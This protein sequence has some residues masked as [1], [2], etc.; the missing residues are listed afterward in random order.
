MI[1]VM[2]QGTPLEVVHGVAESLT[3]WNIEPHVSVGRTQVVI[4]LIGDTSVISES[5]CYGLSPFIE[6]VVRVKNRFKRASRDFH[7]EPTTIAVRGVLIGADHPAVVIAGPCSVESEAMIV[8]TALA[9]KAAGAQFLRGGAFKPRT[10]PYDFQ[11][12]GESALELLAQARA[13]S[14]LGIVTEIMDS[15]DIDAVA[16]VADVL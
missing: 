4:G 2:K 1:I 10:S 13:A 12:H 3:E 14:G 8:E 5:R 16:A 6:K 11:G 15:E 7:P 9:V